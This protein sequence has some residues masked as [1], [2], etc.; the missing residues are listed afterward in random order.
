[1]LLIRKSKHYRQSC[2]HKGFH[3]QRESSSIPSKAENISCFF[4]YKMNIWI[5]IT[6]LQPK[7]LWGIITRPF[8]KYLMWILP[9]EELTALESSFLL[10]VLGQALLNERKFGLKTFSLKQNSF[11]VT[12]PFFKIPFR[13]FWT[14]ELVTVLNVFYAY[15]LT[16]SL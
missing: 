16:Q 14:T 4:T 2:W 12:L 9:K 7:N 15:T 11:L 8:S 1:M 5:S 13:V 3:P 10:G 6:Y